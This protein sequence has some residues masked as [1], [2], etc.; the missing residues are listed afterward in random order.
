[1]DADG[2][3]NDLVVAVG[4]ATATRALNGLTGRRNLGALGYT[5]KRMAR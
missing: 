1:M 3:T 5:P 2:V 4:K